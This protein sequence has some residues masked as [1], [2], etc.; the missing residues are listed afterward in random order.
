M[1]SPRSYQSLEI[2][3]STAP[4]LGSHPPGDLSYVRESV[5]QPRMRQQVIPGNRHSG[6]ALSLKEFPSSKSG[7]QA[8]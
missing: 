1:C 4:V 6:Q 3:S 5:V 2:D 7:F 8:D